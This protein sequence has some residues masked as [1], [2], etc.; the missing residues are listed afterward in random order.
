MVYN[1][2]DHSVAY[3]TKYPKYATYAKWSSG[4]TFGPNNYDVSIDGDLKRGTCSLGGTY[5]YA[6]Y[7]SSTTRTCGGAKFQIRKMEI[8]HLTPP[9]TPAPS[10]TR[11][12]FGVFAAK[13]DG[14]VEVSTIASS[15]EL[16][17]VSFAAGLD[18]TP[19]MWARCYVYGGEVG[20]AKTPSDFHSQCDG[21]GPTV[22]L[23]RLAT[24]GRRFAAYAPAS[25]NST[26]DY[27][28]GIEAMLYSLDTERHE[29]SVKYDQYAMYDNPK[30]FPTFGH[31]YHDLSIS[32]TGD[33]RCY[34]KYAFPTHT[35]GLN[36]FELCSNGQE[37]EEMEVWYLKEQPTVELM[38]AEHSTGGA[39]VGRRSN[40]ASAQEVMAVSMIA[41][42]SPRADLW[43]M[44]YNVAT[45]TNTSQAFHAKCDN[46]GTAL[47][48]L[49]LC[50]T[51]S[52]APVNEDTSFGPTPPEHQGFPSS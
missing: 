6:G 19:G 18:T 2:G 15:A 51:H 34:M 14:A 25:W 39:H 8:W 31:G 52:L 7:A 45:D 9:A 38:L 20:Y 37:L 30:Y 32:A 43:K 46:V 41:G 33:V 36:S 17:A 4:P 11:G 10:E 28:P 13:G 3:S 26:S 35:H 40:V 44:C 22:T 21:K 23:A 48:S 27:I 24:Y 12:T 16:A 1:L 47:F 50:L 49:V 42:Y 5:A 29:F